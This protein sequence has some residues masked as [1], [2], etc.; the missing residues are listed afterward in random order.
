MG[1]DRL[2]SIENAETQSMDVVVVEGSEEIITLDTEELT[3]KEKLKLKLN[4]KEKTLS[5]TSAREK[6]MARLKKKKDAAFS[7]SQLM[8]KAVAG[9]APP[10]TTT[11]KPPPE[12]PGGVMPMIG[13][14]VGSTGFALMI[15]FV[16]FP[17]QENGTR[18]T[19][20][21][22][23]LAH[24]R[25]PWPELAALIFGQ[26]VGFLGW[27]G[28]V[29]RLHKKEKEEALQKEEDDEYEEEEKRRTERKRNDERKKVASPSARAAT[30]VRAD[31]GEDDEADDDDDAGDDDD[32]DE[33]ARSTPD[34]RKPEPK[35]LNRKP[36]S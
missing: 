33:D 24:T 25:V 3:E 8:A 2:E 22:D 31:A 18:L 23:S 30:K 20:W 35:P 12:A 34:R 14:M 29:Y 9:N 10:I 16:F 4:E 13:F 27:A 5:P 28:W 11:T 36:K 7:R 15:L 17:A 32:G 1:G 21:G 19:P 26:V 6:S